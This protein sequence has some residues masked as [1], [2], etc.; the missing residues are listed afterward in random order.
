MCYCLNVEI[1]SQCICIMPKGKKGFQKG[2]KEAIKK[3]GSKYGNQIREYLGYLSSGAARSYYKNLEKLFNGKDLPKPVKEAM[4]RF[5]KNTEFITPKL[6]RSEQKIE[7]ELNI[8]QR[9]LD[10]IYDR[11][12]PAKASGDSSDSK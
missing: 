11:I 8:N 7:G 3:T 2:N 5:E 6:A 9:P 4:D 1:I 10:E 12:Q